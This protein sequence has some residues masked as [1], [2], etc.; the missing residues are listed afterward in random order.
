MRL[1]TYTEL[2]TK[3]QNDLDLED[4]IFI[5][6]EELLGYFNEAIDIAEALIHTLYEDYYFTVANIALTSG[7]ADYSLPA[8]IYAFKIRVINYANGTDKYEI[9]RWRKPLSLLNFVESDEDYKYLPING[10]ANGYQIKLLPAS[11]ETSSTNVTIW[12]IRNAAE[13][14]NDTDICDLPELAINFV[15]QFVKQRCYEKEG[16][17]NTLKAIDDTDKLR[18]AMTETLH[19]MVDDEDTEIRKDLSFYR[20]FDSDLYI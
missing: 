2:K 8:D 13:L 6:P 19:N 20:D 11:R 17:P 10:T 9:K 3:L 7:V 1:W 12:Y 18:I 14:V 5:T 4:E 15:L 16:H